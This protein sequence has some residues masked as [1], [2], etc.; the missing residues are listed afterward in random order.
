MTASTLGRFVLDTARGNK[1]ENPMPE[2]Q[3]REV[4]DQLSKRTSEKVEIIHALQRRAYE[5]SKSVTVF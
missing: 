5:N 2:N 4:R 1:K 3:A